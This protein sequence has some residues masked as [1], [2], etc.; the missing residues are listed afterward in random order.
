MLQD[1]EYR[2]VIVRVAQDDN[3]T[4]SAELVSG[5]WGSAVVSLRK[6]NFDNPT[7]WQDYSAAVTFSSNGTTAFRATEAGY[8]CLQVT[9]AGAADGRIDVAVYTDSPGA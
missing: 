2:P 7:A 6:S 9:T 8:V 1:V 3:I 5:S 4:V